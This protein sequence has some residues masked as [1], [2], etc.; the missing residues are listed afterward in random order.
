MSYFRRNPTAFWNTSGGFPPAAWIRNF[1]QNDW[2]VWK[3][4]LTLIFGYFFSKRR[5]VR[6]ISFTRFSAPHHE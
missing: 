6:L 3:S 2:Y 5:I 4:V 1:S